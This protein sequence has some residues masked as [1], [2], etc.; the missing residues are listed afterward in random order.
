VPEV[1][2]ED[3]INRYPVTSYC[4]IEIPTDLLPIQ[5]AL[6][7]WAW[8]CDFSQA[9]S[10]EVPA[11]RANCA[12]ILVV[13]NGN[14]TVD[15]QEVPSCGDG[16]RA[17]LLP[18]GVSTVAGSAGDG[19]YI[20][21]YA[22]PESS[23]PFPRPPDDVIPGLWYRGKF[24]LGQERNE[25]KGVVVKV[26][27]VDQDPLVCLSDWQSSAVAIYDKYSP[28]LYIG[29]T[30]DGPFEP[31][32]APDLDIRFISASWLIGFER[33]DDAAENRVILLDFDDPSSD[34][35]SGGCGYRCY[36]W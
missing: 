18:T 8:K 4:P 32:V 34:G 9:S 36:S 1:C 16:Q 10:I 17:Q 23:P 28:T 30:E 15:G 12:Y 14:V 29:S 5:R 3:D 6:D 24:P 13:W 20:I 27:N 11:N 2:P 7:I 22:T 26:L 19:A 33:T 21:A 31:F 25:G 35:S